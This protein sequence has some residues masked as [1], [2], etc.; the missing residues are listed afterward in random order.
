MRPYAERKAARIERLRAR[1]ERLTN[2]SASAYDTSTRMASVIPFGQPILVGHYSEGRDRRYR[3]RIWNT[4]GKSVKLSKEAAACERRADAAESNTM[5]SSDDPTAID[6]LKAKLAGLMMEQERDK[7]VNRTIRTAQRHAK[8]EGL[9]FE[10]IALSGLIDMGLTDGQ[11]R[12]A[13]TPNCFGAIGVDGYVL[14]NRS[15]NM[16][17]IEQRLEVLERKAVAKPK[18][19]EAFGD[20]RVEENE[21]RVQVFFPGKPSAE[22]RSELKSHGFRWAPSEGAW[23]RMASDDAWYWA[24]KIAAKGIAT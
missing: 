16:R 20:V 9:P 22:V 4:M 12:D 24:R 2:E 14:T 21:N 3:D 1:A 19:P 8:K 6:Q 5:I 10:P 11:A 13:L 23:Q 15:G 17:R 18:E 7:E